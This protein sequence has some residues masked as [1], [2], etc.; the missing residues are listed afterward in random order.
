MN[1]SCALV[2]GG[3]VWCW[4]SKYSVVSGHRLALGPTAIS[5]LPELESLTAGR[6]HVCG[7]DHDFRVWCWGSN[8]MGQLGV[9]G[10]PGEQPCTHSFMASRH[11]SL[12]PVSTPQCSDT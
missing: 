5:G 7:V 11:V 10:Q 2:E 3:Q 9:R 8:N 1:K 6:D 4:G 12:V